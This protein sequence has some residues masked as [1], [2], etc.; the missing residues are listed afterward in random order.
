[1]MKIAVQLIA[2]SLKGILIMRF[3]TF[4]IVILALS[5][6]TTI[7]EQ[8]QGSYP[9]ISPARVE[10]GV[11][12]SSARW[13]GVILNS[14]NKDSGTCFEV[15]SRELDKYLR[16]ELQDATLGRFI[17]C[18]KGFND[19]II[20][21]KGRE[22]TV[23]GRIQGIEIQK[24]GDFDYRYPVLEVEDLVL[25]EKRKVVM[26]YRGFNDPFYGYGGH[27]GGGY[28][29]GG[30]WGGGYG[31]RYPYYRHPFPSYNT[32]YIEPQTLLPGPAIVE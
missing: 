9:E 12:G 27:W 28:W 20:F 29:G 32:G 30:Y 15:L 16:P 22:I 7:P 5:A 31:G 13:G 2:G 11:F 10:P 24:V 1:M 4:T 3:L 23:T 6:C 25:W 19:P 17:A 18:T 26:R 21:T 8:I 14:K